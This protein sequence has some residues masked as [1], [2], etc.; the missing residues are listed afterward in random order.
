ML[1]AAGVLKKAVADKNPTVSLAALALLRSLLELQVPLSFP[2]SSSFR[3][4]KSLLLMP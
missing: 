4:L 3:Y 1:T 2:L